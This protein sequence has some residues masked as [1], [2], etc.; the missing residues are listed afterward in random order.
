MQFAGYIFFDFLL[1]YRCSGGYWS[2]WDDP[3]CLLEYNTWSMSSLANPTSYNG[4]MSSVK[5]AHYATTELAKLH[6][7][8]KFG[9]KP[10]KKHKLSRRQNL[11]GS[12]LLQNA[13][14]QAT[15]S[16]S[17]TPPLFP[18]P[19]KSFSCYSLFY[20]KA[21]T[22]AM[23]NMFML[24]CIHCHYCLYHYSP[25]THSCDFHACSVQSSN[26]SLILDRFLINHYLPLPNLFSG[27]GQII[28]HCMF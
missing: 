6:W 2:W 27:V 5:K 28:F 23:V 22:L 14:Q 3:G 15:S 11:G 20:E 18:S 26:Q 9:R 16:S 12:P 10:R 4:N 13:K 21:A 7:W 25:F 24:I 8:I 19:P 17:F 1:K